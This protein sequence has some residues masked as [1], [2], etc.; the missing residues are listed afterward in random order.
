ML[1]VTILVPIYG[2]ERYIAECAASLLSQTYADIE[3]VFCDDATPDASLARLRETVA[4]FPGRAASVRIIAN[5]RNSGLGATRARLLKE[6]RTPLFAI[7]DSDDRLP[8]DAI[9]TLVRRQHETG[10][11][12]VEGAYQPFTSVGL[13]ASVL[14]T[15]AVGEAYRRRAQCQNIIANRVW[16]KLYVTEA[17]RRVPNLFIAGIDYAEDLC[18]TLRLAAVTT[19]AWTDTVIYHYRTDNAAS[20]TANITPARLRQYLL[21]SREVLRFYHERGHLPFSLELG[22]LSAYRLCRRYGLPRA[23]VDNIIRYVPEHLTAALLRRLLTGGTASH[24]VGETLYR[25]VRALV[26]RWP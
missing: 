10:A 21:A 12:I 16:G 22:L 23:E 9:A 13:G 15:H 5:E 6:V 25:I 17:V 11:D 19:R 24:A 18:A 14:P 20:Y 4:R 3:Y 26:G 1:R 8:P 7:V 2:V